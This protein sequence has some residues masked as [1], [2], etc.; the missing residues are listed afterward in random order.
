[1][2]KANLNSGKSK[3]TAKTT[4][5]GAEPGKFVVVYCDDHSDL[6]GTSKYDESKKYLE[7]RDYTVPGLYR[8]CDEEVSGD[9]LSVDW[10][11]KWNRFKK[12]LGQDDDGLSTKDCEIYS[13]LRAE[14]RYLEE[15][16]QKM[17]SKYD[18]VHGIDGVF[19]NKDEYILVESKFTTPAK[20]ERY[21][22]GHSPLG[23]LG[24]KKY[25]ADHDLPED[26]ETEEYMRQMS[27]DWISSSFIM[28]RDE[29]RD[30]KTQNTGKRMQYV[31][32]ENIKRVMN[33]FGARPVH[34][35]A[36]CYGFKLRVAEFNDITED[37]YKEQADAGSLEVDWHPNW[38]H[39]GKPY[40]KMEFWFITE[41][42]ENYLYAIREDSLEENK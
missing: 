22:K 14:Y 34:P 40:H 29:G 31:D 13:V 37:I 18:A 42:D 28:M 15:G 41:E 23:H 5:L 9:R 8:Y 25:P 2:T 26:A 39:S 20:Y 6:R 16:Y 17:P 10:E 24:W 35:P 33:V 7:A 21:C 32:R 4:N 36:G 3:L 11:L 1:M 19:K 30:E 12:P 38:L 27:W